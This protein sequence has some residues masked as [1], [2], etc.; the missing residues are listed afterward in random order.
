MPRAYK[1]IEI[2]CQTEIFREFRDCRRC[3]AGGMQLHCGYLMS[4][5]MAHSDTAD[6]VRIVFREALNQLFGE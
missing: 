1:E 4:A 3:E 2:A 6:G 5:I